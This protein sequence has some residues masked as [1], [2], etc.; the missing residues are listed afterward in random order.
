MTEFNISPI[1]F[2]NIIHKLKALPRQGWISKVPKADIESISDHAFGVSFLAV[3]LLPL[4]NQMRTPET[5]LNHVRCLE[6]AIL[7]DVGEGLY[8]DIDLTL[9]N[10]LGAKKAIEIKGEL[11]EASEL[12]IQNSFYQFQQRFDI[13]NE[14]KLNFYSSKGSMSEEDHFVKFLDLLELYL[15]TNYYLTQGLLSEKNASS[16][17]HGTREGLEKYKSRIKI[18]EKLLLALL[19]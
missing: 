3:T 1:E 5:R 19:D 2:L 12:E 16:F 6:K 10:L 18:C 17:L 14:I 7:H 4:E 11:D 8:F 15:Q 9:K 13:R